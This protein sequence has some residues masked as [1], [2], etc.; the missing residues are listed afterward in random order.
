[1]IKGDFMAVFFEFH[2]RGEFVKSITLLLLL[3]FRKLMVLRGSRT[4]VLVV[5]WAGFI[6]LLLRCWLIE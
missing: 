1:V 6:R 5:L 2:D 4:F 3:L